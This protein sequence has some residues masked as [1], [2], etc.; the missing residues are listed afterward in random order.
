MVIVCLDRIEHIRMH[1]K[2]KGHEAMHAEMVLVLLAA[3]ILGQVVLV[4]WRNK[5][6]RS[7]QVRSARAS[8]EVVK[9][10]L[11]TSCLVRLAAR[12]CVNFS[13]G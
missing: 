1:E 4:F 7:Y 6:P 8:P 2:H 9:A 5:H 3:L 12:A 13:L 10:G 11:G